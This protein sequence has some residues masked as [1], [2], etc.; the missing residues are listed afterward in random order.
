MK[1]SKT[2]CNRR[3]LPPTGTHR[4]TKCCVKLEEQLPTQTKAFTNVLPQPCN[5]ACFES[6][7]P[8]S[9][10]WDHRLHKW[11]CRSA[12]FPLSFCSAVDFLKKK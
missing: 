11:D 12:A 5:A 2:G 4:Y 3:H 7:S 8:S 1:P 10:K 9:P 6:S